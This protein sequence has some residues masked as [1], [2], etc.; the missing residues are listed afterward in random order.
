MDGLHHEKPDV[1]LGI[2]GV[3][4]AEGIVRIWTREGA[5]DWW[6][7]EHR[8]LR[9]LLGGGRVDRELI[10]P[11]ASLEMVVIDPS[12]SSLTVLAPYQPEEQ[13]I[14]RLAPPFTIAPVLA[15]E[16]RWSEKTYATLLPWLSTVIEVASYRGETLHLHERKWDESGHRLVR[17]G[18]HATEGNWSAFVGTNSRPDDSDWLDAVVQDPVVEMRIPASE[19][20][21]LHAATLAL[22]LLLQWPGGPLDVVLAWMPGRCGA[23]PRY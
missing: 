2:I 11:P 6:L 1:H 12:E 21:S 22:Q 16:L 10:L 15:G 17:I 7:A 18:Y 9:G 5:Q 3:V 23:R 14:F 20:S 13:R 4:T 19:T 8:Q